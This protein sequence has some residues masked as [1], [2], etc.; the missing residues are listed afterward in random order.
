MSTLSKQPQGEPASRPAQADS[1]SRCSS[2]NEA[3]TGHY[4]APGRMMD[5]LTT[6]VRDPSLP[7]QKRPCVIF[8]AWTRLCAGT[9]GPEINPIPFL[10][11]A[12]PPPTVRTTD[13]S[14]EWAFF[15]RLDGRHRPGDVEEEPR[16]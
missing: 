8:P 2:L 5:S 7:P 13:P 6:P 14:P 15:V 12:P 9:L 1:E 3:G 10:E 11:L 4:A 16:G